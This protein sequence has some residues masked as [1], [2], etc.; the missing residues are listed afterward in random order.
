MALKSDPID[1]EKIKDFEKFSAVLNTLKREC[2]SG[3]L[4][5]KFQGIVQ[6]YGFQDEFDATFPEEKKISPNPHSHL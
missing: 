4:D 6:Q 2:S 3:I 1:P 5:F